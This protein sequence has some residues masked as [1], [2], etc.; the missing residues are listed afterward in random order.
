[1]SKRIDLLH[2]NRKGGRIFFFFL[3]KELRD[4]HERRTE[5]ELSK[6]R[7]YND[8]RS[9]VFSCVQLSY[10]Q[11]AF[12]TRSSHCSGKSFLVINYPHS[13]GLFK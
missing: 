8:T 3:Q 2:C 9:N 4:E 5:D 11:I 7:E 6:Q 12:L 13:S 10:I 1:M